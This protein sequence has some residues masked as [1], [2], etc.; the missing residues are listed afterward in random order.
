MTTTD[1]Q[2]KKLAHE[3]DENPSDEKYDVKQSMKAAIS[4]DDFQK[5]IGNL[6]SKI[7][8]HKAKLSSLSGSNHDS[9]PYNQFARKQCITLSHTVALLPRYGNHF[10]TLN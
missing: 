8:G 10:F 2:D 4:L 9:L 7:A 3:A 1:A 5:D 6:E